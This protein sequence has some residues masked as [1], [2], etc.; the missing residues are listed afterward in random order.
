MSRQSDAKRLFAHLCD[1]LPAKLRGVQPTICASLEYDDLPPNTP[2]VVV[3]VP[4]QTLV[5][6]ATSRNFMDCAFLFESWFHAMITGAGENARIRDF[7]TS[8][9]RHLCDFVCEDKGEGA[10]A[11][12][13]LHAF[14]LSTGAESFASEN[15]FLISKKGAVFGVQDGVLITPRRSGYVVGLIDAEAALSRTFRRVSDDTIF[16]HVLGRIRRAGLVEEEAALIALRRPWFDLPFRALVKACVR[17]TDQG[18]NDL[19]RAILSAINRPEPAKNLRTLLVPHWMER[20]TFAILVSG[21]PNT[22]GSGA[23]RNPPHFSRWKRERVL[24]NLFSHF[25]L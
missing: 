22:G 16:N 19:R 5:T 21:K 23:Y 12:R 6:P 25:N 10:R 14:A 13:M 1:T 20:D 2:I 24:E 4:L 18:T 7:R 9:R 8:E 15:T 11:A 3:G 17:G